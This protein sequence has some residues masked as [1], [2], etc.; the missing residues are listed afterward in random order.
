[1]RGRGKAQHTAEGE[2]VIVDRATARPAHADQYLRLP[3]R[4]QAIKSA[5]KMFQK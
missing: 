2:L 1:M 3:R 4:M 5:G